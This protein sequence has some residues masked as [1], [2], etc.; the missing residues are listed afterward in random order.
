MF[1]MVTANVSGQTVLSMKVNGNLIKL[2]V[3]V[4]SI[5]F[6]GTN[7][8]AIGLMT[9]LMAKAFIPTQT[10]LITQAHGV[11]IYK[12]ASDKNNGPTEVNT[13]AIMF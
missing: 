12:T 1:V 2:T 8:K 13:K 3:G 5:T 6:T 10:V 4:F 9:K 11:T 7:M